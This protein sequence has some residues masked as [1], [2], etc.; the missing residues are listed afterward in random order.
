MSNFNQILYLT[1][2]IFRLKT[3]FEGFFN[4]CSRKFVFL[5]MKTLQSAFLIFYLLIP[6][7]SCNKTK[8]TTVSGVVS[9]AA[10]GL[11]LSGVIVGI[12]ASKYKTENDDSVEYSIGGDQDTTNINGLYSLQIETE[13]PESIGWYAEKMGYVRKPYEKI[14]WGDQINEDFEMRPIDAFI[15]IIVTNESNYTGKTYCR[16][17]GAEFGEHVA[18]IYPWPFLVSPDSMLTYNFPTAGGQFIKIYWGENENYVTWKS[19]NAMVDSVFCER[20]DT[21]EYVLKL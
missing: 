8:I 14:E 20:N 9:D 18:F 2:L 17:A 21:V 10:T 7:I 1:F 6:L 3:T 19:N 13:C 12:G 5:R 4:C 16:V 15:R 11:P